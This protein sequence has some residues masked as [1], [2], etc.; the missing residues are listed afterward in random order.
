MIFVGESIEF[1]SN[2]PH[3]AKRHYFEVPEDG[4]PDGTVSPGWYPCSDYPQWL[5]LIKN[6]VHRYSPD[7]RI[8]FATYNWSYMDTETRLAFL[9]TLPKDITLLIDMELGELRRYGGGAVGY[10][11]DYTISHPG[12]GTY[13]KT[14]AMEAK[15]LGLRLSCY[16]GT[17]GM[18]WDMGTIPYQP[19]AYAWME[20]Y[21]ALMDKT[22]GWDVAELEESIHFGVHPSFI[23]DLAKRIFY[24]PNG[25]MEQALS[26]VLCMHF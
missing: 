14:E 15:R 1:P 18:T 13:F 25:S 22:Q 16:S 3:V 12:P 20:R 6:T 26:D 17:G 24:D 9:H 4:I 5:E 8:I 2:D 11:S 23:T 7:T 10:C 21:A 19:V